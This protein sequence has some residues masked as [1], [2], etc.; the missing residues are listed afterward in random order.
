[1]EPSLDRSALDMSTGGVYTAGMK[2]EKVVLW[3]IA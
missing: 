3:R 1:M 2:V